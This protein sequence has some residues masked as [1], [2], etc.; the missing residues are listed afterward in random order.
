MRLKTLISTALLGLAALPVAALAGGG[1]KVSGVEVFLDIPEFRF[2]QF[3][4]R[5]VVHQ[6]ILLIKLIILPVSQSDI[7][8]CI[9]ICQVPTVGAHSVYSPISKDV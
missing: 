3:D 5:G 9:R 4:F 6:D 1:Q 8:E 2:K 7:V